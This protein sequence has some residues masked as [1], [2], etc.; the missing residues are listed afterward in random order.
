MRLN[1]LKPATGSR[2]TKVRVGRGGARGKTAGRG[3]K[4]QRS[5]SGYSHVGEGGQMPL[6]RRLPKVGFRSRKSLFRD[7]V[8]LSALN[9]IDPID[10]DLAVLKKY[11]LVG[12]RIRFVKII[13]KGSIERAVTIKGIPVTK[14]ARVA[15]ESAGGKIISGD[16][17]VVEAVDEKA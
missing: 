8:R 4:G 16:D 7:E 3:H 11:G 1:T 9:R 13:L 17:V 15:I 14:G 12:H 5:R 6:E 2:H 10:I